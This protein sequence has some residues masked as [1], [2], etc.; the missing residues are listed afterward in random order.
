MGNF[1]E[2]VRAFIADNP[3][4][5]TG[6]DMG[7]IIVPFALLYAYFG[8]TFIAICGEIIALRRKRSAYNKCARQLACLSMLLGW[9]M[10]LGGVCGSSW[11]WTVSTPT[12]S[13][14]CSAKPPG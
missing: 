10:L 12:A 5:Q 9:L 3:L 6:L 11:R 13:S 1:L 8:L 7:S 14:S 4:L 2:S